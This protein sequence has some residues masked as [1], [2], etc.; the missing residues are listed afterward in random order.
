M[1]TLNITWILIL[2]LIP[3]IGI[4]QQ[5]FQ[6]V[7]KNI[8]Y[9]G[10]DEF[11]KNELIQKNKDASEDFLYF[12]DS[13][14][15]SR[16]LLL[17]F[18]DPILS[19]ISEKK[20]YKRKDPEENGGLFFKDFQLESMLD[21]QPMLLPPWSL[22]GRKKEISGYLCEEIEYDRTQ[23]DVDDKRI[24]RINLWVTRSL[25]NHEFIEER[26][27]ILG[28]ALEKTVFLKTRNGYER[29]TV[30]FEYE[31]KKVDQPEAFTFAINEVD[32]MINFK[33]VRENP[34]SENQIIDKKI[35]QTINAIPN[36]DKNRKL[37]HFKEL[38]PTNPTGIRTK[39]TYYDNVK[40]GWIKMTEDGSKILE[41]DFRYLP[42]DTIFTNIDITDFSK[43]VSGRYT[44]QVRQ[45]T[46][47]KINSKYSTIKECW[48]LV[49]KE[50]LRKK[51]ELKSNGLVP[52]VDFYYDE[53]LLL[54][55]K[56]FHPDKFN[57]GLEIIYQHNKRGQKISQISLPKNRKTT[58]EYYPNGLR[59]KECVE[60]GCYTYDYG[61]KINE[62]G[63]FIY[64]KITISIDKKETKVIKEFDERHNL[65]KRI[66][67]DE[68]GKKTTKRIEIEYYKTTSNNNKY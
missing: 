52:D 35:L 8:S 63:S 2:F 19:N 55:K 33:Q 36:L 12:T 31:V 29:G 39:T 30:T 23:V 21:L 28:M 6:R 46:V 13:W 42:P 51:L 18:R 16:R 3:N 62:D 25:P 67:I 54:T 45:D 14:A 37:T 49:N 65:I 40:L 64:S 22:T 57:D 50:R 10:V 9:S 47:C 15:Y 48:L 20:I 59:S 43:S 26:S 4:S 27:P 34:V 11:L 1:K 53:N 58:Y 24:Q 68:E 56:Y 44:Y 41:Y 17:P 32:K 38:A 7:I 5:C 61:L 60:K 66:N